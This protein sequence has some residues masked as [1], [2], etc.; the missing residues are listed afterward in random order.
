MDYSKKIPEDS[1]FANILLI[2]SLYYSNQQKIGIKLLVFAK[3]YKFS[4]IGHCSAQINTNMLIFCW[5]GH[6]FLI[7]TPTTK[8]QEL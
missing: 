6:D 2:W 1:I 7:V 5:F 3:S 4:E 8:R